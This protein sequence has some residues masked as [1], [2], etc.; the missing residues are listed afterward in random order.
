MIPMLYP[1][2]N[3]PVLVVEN[4]LKTMVIA[5]IHLGIEWDLYYSG[6]NIPSQ[7]KKR[8]KRILGYVA[9]SKPDKIVLLGDVKH[10]VPHVSFQE[11]K[12]IPFFLEQMARYA[13]VEIIPGNHDGRIK[14]LLPVRGEVT[15]HGSEGVTI[16]GVGY[17]HGHAWPAAELFHARE[18]VMGH[19]HPL[20]KFADPLGK[21][22]VE[23][24]WVNA[25]FNRSA[26]IKR[27]S[28]K[29]SWKNPRL[30]IM[31][32]FNELCGGIPFN[33]A[34]YAELLGPMFTSKAVE[35]EKANCYLLDGTCLGEVG[36]LRIPM[37]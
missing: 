28:E 35:L 15:L 1:L 12:E 21:K 32:A 10:N 2:V 25:A 31:P 14:H 13:S 23:Q 7:T 27:Y 4:K 36:N 29:I 34:L 17:F 8:L 26:I 11:R 6:F 18:V 33:E 20:I 19:N 22:H 30:T 37:K 3:S 24:V 16:D 5:D 9:E